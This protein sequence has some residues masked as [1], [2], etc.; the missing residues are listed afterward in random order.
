MPSHLR[1]LGLRASLAIGVVAIGLGSTTMAIAAGRSGPSLISPRNGHR[2]RAGV[3]NLIVRDSSSN[4]ARYGVFVT[5]SPT[6]RLN[7]YRHLAECNS[8][9]RG[10]DFVKLRRRPGHRGEWI[11]RSHFNFRGYWATTP[12]RYYVQPEHVD[13]LANGGDRVG[14][15]GSFRVVR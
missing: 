13:A 10:C 15:I 12:R 5:I 3:I 4:A 1:K 6:R 9:S 8:V 11:Y 14:P 7:R 2:I